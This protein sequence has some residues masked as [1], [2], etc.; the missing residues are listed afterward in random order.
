MIITLLTDFGTQ[1]TFAGVLHGVIKTI[2][3]DADVVTLTHHVPPQDIAAGAF[4]WKTAYRH[5]PAGTVHL[6]IVDPGVGSVRRPIAAHIG[7]YVYVCPDNGLVSHVLSE[8]TLHSAVILDNTLYQR[9]PPSRTF[10]GRDIFAPAAAHLTRGVPL[11]SLGTAL[12]ALDAFPLS[13]PDFGPDVVTCHVLYTDVYGNV[14][15]DFTETLY[16][17]APC[18]L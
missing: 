18:A 14:F 8:D 16:R 9:S 15:T 4:L 13:A 6:G 3:P 1:D 17:H 10:H 12:D 5:F 2:A 7:D 11:H